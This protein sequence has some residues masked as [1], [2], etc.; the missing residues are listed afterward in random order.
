M[1]EK[2]LELLKQSNEYHSGEELSQRFGVTRAAVWKSIKQL[3][4]LGYVIESKTRKGYRLVGT[5]DIL[6]ES[7]L[8]DLLHS[9]FLSYSI[10]H[11][12]NTSSTNDF[13][14]QLAEQNQPE[15]HVVISEYQTKGRGKKHSQWE[16]AP[17]KGIYLS[18][19][20]RPE[21]GVMQLPKLTICVQTAVCLALE[22]VTQEKIQ[23]QWPY[24]LYCHGKKLCGI[25]LESFGSIE[26]LDYTI[27]GIGIQVN[28][29]EDE[30]PDGMTSLLLVTQRE[31][32]RKQLAAAVLN[33]LDIIYHQ[34][35]QGQFGSVFQQ[36]WHHYSFQSMPEGDWEYAGI[37]EDYTLQAVEQNTGKTICL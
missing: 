10:H 12:T 31:Q 2:I 1:K 23:C 20:L 30:L 6:F 17:G 22:Q 34:F 21:I 14:K 13:A 15:G 19:V 33:H 7:E 16:A 24:S 28:A 29:D 37:A 36:Y 27:A 3:E 5:P 11:L 9:K 26:Q 32:D 4:A 8:T 25:L 35:C 18:V